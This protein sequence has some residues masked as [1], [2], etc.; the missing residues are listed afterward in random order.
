ML[1][2][3][4]IA[5]SLI[6]SLG[7]AQIGAISHEFSHFQNI[8]TSQQDAALANSAASAKFA[9]S[10]SPVDPL[11]SLPHTQVC[12]KCVSYAE[13]SPLLYQHA[14][15]DF[16]QPQHHNF[17]FLTALTYQKSATASYAARAPPHF[18]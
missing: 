16:S 7:V 4:I 10:Q 17:Q 1:H 6:V 5:F 13:A 14:T 11:D 18:A 9:S 3:L 15:P 8:N 2:R 12:E